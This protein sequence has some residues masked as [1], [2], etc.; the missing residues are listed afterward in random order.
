MLSADWQNLARGQVPPEKPSAFGAGL[1]QKKEPK[2][3]ACGACTL[4]VP[5]FGPV[6]YWMPLRGGSSQGTSGR[7]VLPVG[8][9]SFSFYRWH[10]QIGAHGRAS[11]HSS[12]SY[13][14]SAG[15][16]SWPRSLV[17]NSL[18]APTPTSASSKWHS[19][20][21]PCLFER[22]QSAVSR[23]ALGLL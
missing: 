16:V 11:A 12:S 18:S 1:D 8:L 4:C 14:S 13:K 23:G 10:Q 6:A 7:Q 19:R 2:N 22:P 9:E 20:R 17:H 5:P 15:N 21:L 3:R